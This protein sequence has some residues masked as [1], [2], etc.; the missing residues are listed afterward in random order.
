MVHD[1]FSCCP[2]RNVLRTVRSG[3]NRSLFPSV[4]VNRSLVIEVKNTG[5]CLAGCHIMAEV[6]INVGRH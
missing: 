1:L 2:P 6:G 5:H 3:F 4:E